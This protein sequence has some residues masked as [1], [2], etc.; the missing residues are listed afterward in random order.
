[1]NKNHATEI[2]MGIL[3]I[4]SIVLVAV[5][6]LVSIPRGLLLGIYTTDFIICIIFAWDFIQRLRASENRGR[7]LKT[8]G[9]EI[10]AM[11]P[12][13][14]F[15]ALGAIP[16][17]SSGL[18][19]LRLIRVVRVIVLL[20]RMRRV[21]STNERFFQRSHLLAL[22]G[23]CLI[24]VFIGSFTVLILERNT[25]SAQIT[26]FSDAIWWSISTITTVGYGDIVPHTIAGRIMGIFLMVVGIGVMAALISE[27]SAVMVEARIRNDTVQSDL[28]M[29]M[30]N[31]IK[32]H[33][34]KIE[35]L[36]ESEVTLLMQ[37][38]RTLRLKDPE[39]EAP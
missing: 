12:A 37:M 3:A 21:M 7:F 28:K 17:I 29:S 35:T 13:F 33:I 1:M 5:E 36:S 26:N 25:A 10:L 18:R 16:V 19:T 39:K 8:N 30:I 14:A 15:A 27:V 4:I 38:I 22:L 34:D 11:I 32:S 31:E 23:I 24:I 2:I 20:A 9:Y 6:S